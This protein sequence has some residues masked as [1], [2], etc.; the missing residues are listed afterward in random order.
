[1]TV[2]NS[3]QTRVSRK[4]PPTDPTNRL[5]QPR[6][7]TGR[8][9]NQ[10]QQRAKKRE[11]AG[12]GFSE[13]GC[14]AEKMAGSSDASAKAPEVPGKARKKSDP[15]FEQLFDVMGP[16]TKQDREAYSQEMHPTWFR[17]VSPAKGT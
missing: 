7:G 16:L 9:R 4:N 8:G 13:S 15:K 12:K 11:L 17:H 6:E 10:P 2:A 3:H 1:M 14:V 5:R